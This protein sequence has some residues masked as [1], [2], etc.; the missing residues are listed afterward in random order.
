MPTLMS[1]LTALGLASSVGA[2]AFIPVLALGVFHHTQYFELAPGWV[3]IASPPV[4]A[5]MAVLAL[6][7]IAVDSNPELGEYA[8]FVHY[9]PKA[10]AGFIA[11]AAATGAVHQSLAELTG[12]GLLGAATAV[13]THHVR[14]AARRQL[15]DHAE[16]VLPRVGLVASLGEATLAAGAAGTAVVAP[17]AGV[18]LMAGAGVVAMASTA[19]VDGWRKACV[20]PDCGQEI[21]P[22][23]S[24]CRHC[25]R[26]QVAQDAVVA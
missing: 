23:A 13:G 20:H 17:V 22:E 21:R 14:S 25:G 8:D 3:W 5:I 18:A 6:A 19:W 2:K 26:D 4:M 12:S 11:F 24:V 1:Y 7:E 15:R 16:A 9:L 10:V